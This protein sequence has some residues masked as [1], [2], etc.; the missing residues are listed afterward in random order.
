MKT[1]LA[2]LSALWQWLARL[3]P[4]K[5][6]SGPMQAAAFVRYDGAS[7]AGHVG[8]AFDGRAI[9]VNAGSV[10]NPLGTPTC[11]PAKMGYWDI[12]VE[13]PMPAMI[14]RGYDALKHTGLPFGDPFKAHAVAKWI[15]T[16]PYAVIGRNC[17]DDAY[18]VLRAYGVPNLPPPSHDWLPNEWF[19]ILDC[20]LDSVSTYIWQVPIGTGFR[21]T[22]D[23]FATQH[24]APLV[25][26]WRQPGQ[27]DWHDL[28]SQL[29]D[30]SRNPVP[31]APLAKGP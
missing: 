29:N 20:T 25:P 15:A 10:E 4:S 14:Q 13:G 5:G 19:A 22:L 1:L 17:L 30:V 27:A 2:L 28:Q 21:Q 8:W 31:S 26:T 23:T 9:G 7:G 6:G 24:Q 16:Q 3:T 11:D 18:D 12:F